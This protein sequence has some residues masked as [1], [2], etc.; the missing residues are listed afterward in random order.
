MSKKVYLRRRDLG[1][2]LPKAVKA[3]AKTR[4]SSIYVNRQP[5]KGFSAEEEKKYL[6]GIKFSKI[7]S[8]NKNHG[9][10]E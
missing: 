10:T 1:G 9:L 2:H 5:L 8:Y 4:L 7:S 3:E 6:Q